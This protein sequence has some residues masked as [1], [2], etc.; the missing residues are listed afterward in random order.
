MSV[1]EI[2]L[3]LRATA[4]VDRAPAAATVLTPVLLGL[5]SVPGV[6]PLAEVAGPGETL[7]DLLRL[8]WTEKQT[9]RDLLGPSR[10][11]P[12]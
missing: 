11:P 5:S 12:Q 10:T 9:M 4:G 6:L 2:A 3:P 7:W 8:S 1:L